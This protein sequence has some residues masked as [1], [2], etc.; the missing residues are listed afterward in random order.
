MNALKLL[1]EDIQRLSDEQRDIAE[2][3][4]ELLQTHLENGDK[5]KAKKPLEKLNAIL[6]AITSILTIASFVGLRIPIK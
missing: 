2:A 6:G 1:H 3:N 4:F 5:E